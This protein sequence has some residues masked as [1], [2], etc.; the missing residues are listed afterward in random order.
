MSSVS[1]HSGYWQGESVHIGLG[2]GLGKLELDLIQ[3]VT[4][5]RTELPPESELLQTTSH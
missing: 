3:V 1:Q 5:D 2:H 4:D